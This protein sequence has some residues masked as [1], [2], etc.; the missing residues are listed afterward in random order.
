MPTTTY[1]IR[2][3]STAGTGLGSF[4][5]TGPGCYNSGLAIGGDLLYQGSDGCNHVWVIKKSDHSAAFNFAT[6]V[7][8][9]SNFRDED[10]E[11]DSVTFSPQAVMWS[12]EAYEPLRAVASE[13]PPGSCATGGGVDSD[14][15]GLLDEWEQDGAW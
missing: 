14:G 12:V 8:G 5:C 1:T 3:Y 4:A 9:D 15:D 7:T 6:D 2:H 10:L 11:C 13:V